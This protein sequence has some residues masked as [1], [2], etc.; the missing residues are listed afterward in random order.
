CAT[1]AEAAM[2][3]RCG[4][5]DVL[6]AFPLFGPRLELFL[7]LGDDYPSSQFSTIVDEQSVAEQLSEAA[8]R[9]DTEVGVYIDLDI[10]MGRTGVPMESMAADLYVH[11]HSLPGLR[12][13]GLHAYDGQVREP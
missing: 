3:G 11:C 10:G 2:L 7:Q 13:L 4:A 12:V 5:P 6:V 1:L 9:R 8:Q